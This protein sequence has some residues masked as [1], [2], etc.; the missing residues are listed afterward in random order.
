M[1]MRARDFP[2]GLLGRV[3][4]FLAP[5]GGLLVCTMVLMLSS[6][7]EFELNRAW[8]SG[9]RAGWCVCLVLTIITSWLLFN[10]RREL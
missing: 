4:M 2:W 9:A 7:E 1:T 5:Y 8:E 3:V 10:R 6:F